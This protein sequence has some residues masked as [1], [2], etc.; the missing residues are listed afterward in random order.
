MAIK[1]I[2]KFELSLNEKNVL[3]SECN[4]LELCHHPNI[5]KLHHIFNTRTHLYIVTEFLGEGDLFEYVKSNSFLEEY[6]AALIMKQLVEVLKYFDEVGLIHRDLKPENVMIIMNKEKSIVQKVKIIDFGFAVYKNALKGMDPKE[7]YAGTPGFIPPEIVNCEDFDESVDIF[8]LGVILYFML[9]G[10][11]PFF[12][13]FLEEII[14]QTRQ[15][16]IVLKNAH[17]NNVSE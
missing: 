12:S 16:N 17:W 2:K 10:S 6:E 15:C 11:L 8:S 14:E 5:L 13:S 1:V 7:K 4:I 3:K 9:C